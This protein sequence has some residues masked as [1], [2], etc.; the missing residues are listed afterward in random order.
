M[1]FPSTGIATPHLALE[2]NPIAKWLGWK[3]GAVLRVWRT[4]GQSAIDGSFAIQLTA[5]VHP[6][7]FALCIGFQPLGL[8]F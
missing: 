6:L 5:R 1:D 7:G 2:G 3:W 8:I 4:A